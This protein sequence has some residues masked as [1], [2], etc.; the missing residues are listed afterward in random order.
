M[1]PQF[2]IGNDVNTT[3][4]TVREISCRSNVVVLLVV[5]D[6]T[7]LITYWFG[8]I[9]FSGEEKEYTLNLAEKVHVLRNLS[10]ILPFIVDKYEF[11]TS[12][13]RHSQN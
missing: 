2:N 10:S 4:G 1:L 6:I 11:S 5:L 9:L 7:V 12:M 3:N 13:F 8:L